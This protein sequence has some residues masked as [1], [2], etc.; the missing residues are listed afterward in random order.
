MKFD[1]P[2]PLVR[3][4]YLPRDD[5]LENMRQVGEKLRNLIK[6]EEMES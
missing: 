6:E 1:L 5:D 4:Q 2:L 3:V